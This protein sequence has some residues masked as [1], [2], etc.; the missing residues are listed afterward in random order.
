MKNYAAVA[1]CAV[2]AVLSLVFAG[3]ELI[4]GNQKS[5]LGGLILALAAIGFGHQELVYARKFARLMQ[6]PPFTTAASGFPEQ[7][8]REIR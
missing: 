5:E 2:V 8:K 4:A 7:A 1:V 6:R 3:C